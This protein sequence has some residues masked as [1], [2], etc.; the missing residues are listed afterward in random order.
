MEYLKFCLT[1]F[2]QR[3]K[4]TLYYDLDSLVSKAKL[5]KQM[6]EEQGASRCSLLFPVKAFPAPEVLSLLADIVDGFEVS[7][8]Q[9]LALIR[10]SLSADHIIWHSSPL[11]ECEE[12]APKFIDCYGG[13]LEG[14]MNSLRISFG[15]E[16]FPQTR[17][18][19]ALKE[20]AQTIKTLFSN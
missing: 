7:N 13:E 18:G 10:P 2:K 1:D 15:S 12:G 5:L 16:G 8:A 3:K 17:F 6:L 4:A 14:A 20:I 9:E 11:N 19:V